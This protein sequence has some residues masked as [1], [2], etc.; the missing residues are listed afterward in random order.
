MNLIKEKLQKFKESLKIKEGENNKK[1][2]ENLVLLV[3][4]IIITN[5]TKFSIIFLLFS[6]SLIFNDSLNFC[7]F[8]LIKFIP[9]SI[10]LIYNI[11]FL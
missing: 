5:N 2:I 6:P 8:S 3:I 11:Y 10:I 1:I 9:P 7:S 4:I